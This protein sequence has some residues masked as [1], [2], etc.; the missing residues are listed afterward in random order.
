MSDERLDLH[1][2]RWCFEGVVPAV[3]ST[4]S[5]DGTPNVTYLSRVR[6]VDDEHIALSNQFFSKTTRNLAE[7]PRASLLLVDPIEY[8][9]YRLTLRYERT[10]RSGELF[11]RLRDD[12]NAV[13]ELTGMQD[14]FKLRGADIYRVD[15]IEEVSRIGR[16]GRLAGVE[17]DGASPAPSLERVSELTTRLGRCP[18]LDT[19]VGSTVRW[20]DQLLGYEHSSLLLLDESGSRLYTIASHGY[21]TEGVGSEIAV[22][23]GTA[24]MAAAR[25]RPIRVGNLRQMRKYSTTVRRSYEDEGIGPGHEVPLP[26]LDGVESRVAVPAMALGQLIGVLMVESPRRL[27]F[28]D[29]DEHALSVVAS[30][31]ASAIELERARDRTAEVAPAR[32]STTRASHS[33]GSTHVR[34]F[35]VDGSTFIDGDYLIK[36]VAGRILW[37]LLGQHGKSGRVEFTNREVRL[38]PTLELP[39]FRDN[40]E[41]RLILLKRRLDERDAPIRI[42]NAGRGRFRLTVDTTLHLDAG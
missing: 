20:L 31:V 16:R 14:V 18:D 4:A 10:V 9:E 1:R 15:A 19:L 32:A 35:S 8:D 2:L 13:A 25:T 42:E 37:S 26:D 7:N 22:G 5:S 12:V 17:I 6:F 27:A 36:G 34:F 28:D 11:T 24:G 23:E 3:I 41:S 21:D 40:F 29:A 33:S 39:Q 38:D 30:V